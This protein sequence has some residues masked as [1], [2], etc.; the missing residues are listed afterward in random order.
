MFF[1]NLDDFLVGY[2]KPIILVIHKKNQN[3]IS[4]F[5][6]IKHG[7]NDGIVDTICNCCG[8]AATRSFLIIN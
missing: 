6:P 2:F 4:S 7:E 8:Y 1:I 5:K 3:I